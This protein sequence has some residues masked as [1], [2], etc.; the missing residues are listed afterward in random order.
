SRMATTLSACIFRN[1]E[2]HI[3]HV[4]DCRVYLIR[5]GQAKRFTSDH[6]YVQMQLKLG[7]ISKV[8]AMS[9][10][11]RS[12]LT[13]TLGQNPI[14]QVDFVK[15]TLNS[16]DCIILCSDGLHGSL[17]EHEIAETVTRMGPK[18]AC[19]YL[20]TTAENRG[21]EDNISVQVIRVEEVR[22]TSFYRGLSSLYA[23]PKVENASPVS[24]EIEVGQVLDDRFE[25]SEVIHRSGMSTVFQ[26]VD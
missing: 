9:S 25:I 6:T 16:R 24:T 12:V 20:I 18:E 23:N 2:V 4:G 17:M 26:A 5:S 7:L 22:Q 14:V 10:E 15:S 1:K 13:R 3:G 11:L 19:E 21:A 8:D